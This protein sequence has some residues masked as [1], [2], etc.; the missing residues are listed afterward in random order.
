V[1]V[2]AGAVPTAVPGTV[3]S[4]LGW[5]GRPGAS[6]AVAAGRYR[7]VAVPLDRFA[8]RVCLRTSQAVYVSDR[9]RVRFV[10]HEATLPT[11]P[12]AVVVDA[13]SLPGC[14]RLA[15]GAPVRIEDGVLAAGHA[16][17]PV[18]QVDLTSTPLWDSPLEPAGP[19]D[20]RR[21]RAALG[22]VR[23]AAPPGDPEVVRRVW[24]MLDALHGGRALDPAL[25][26]L[27]GFGPGLTPSGDDATV[28]VLAVARRLGDPGGADRDGV[29]GRLVPAV[30]ERSGRTT[31]YGAFHLEQACAGRVGEALTGVLEAVVSGAG[32]EELVRSTGVL[33]GVGATSG[34]DLSTGLLEAL[35]RWC[36]ARGGPAGGPGRTEGGRPG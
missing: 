27:I 20:P 23:A 32:S 11:A 9:E 4:R 15:A 35:D 36:E 30:L 33:A 14:G 34:R 21:V 18:L 3:S 2:V 31:A 8:G 26:R 17:A 10:V 1:T 13:G 5:S 12:G 19:V 25:D 16:P 28:A 29:F 7:S 24:A 6:G 22:V